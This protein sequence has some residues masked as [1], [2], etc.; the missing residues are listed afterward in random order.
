MFILD[1]LRDV[2]DGEIHVGAL[3]SIIY[4][5][6]ASVYSERPYGVIYPKTEEDIVQIINFASLH[7]INLIPRAAGTSLAGQVVG[8]G[9]AVDITKYFNQIIEVNETEQYA[10]VQPG[11]VRDELN[12]QLQNTGLFF[13]PET[14]TSNRC[15][16]GGMVGNN[17]CGANSLIYGSTRQHIISLKAILSDGSSVEF[18]ELT[19]QEFQDKCKLEN[20]EGELYRNIYNL[21]SPEEIQQEIREQFPDKSIQR[22]SMG[23]AIDELIDM[24]PF[25]KNGNPFNL[26][27]LIAGSEGTLAFITEIKVKLSPLPHPHKA[28]LSVQTNSIEEAL[29]G[30]IIALAYKPA[31]IELIDGVILELAKENRVQNKNRFFIKDNPAAVLIIEVVENSQE[32]VI[33]KIKN[34]Q[35]ALQKASIGNYFTVIE[36]DDMSRVWALRKSGLGIMSNAKGDA[37]PATVVE[38]V[39]IQPEKYPQYYQEFKKLLD[40]F[41]LKCAF[42]AHIS[43]GELHNKPI[44]N[45]KDKEEVKKF[46]EFAYE[47]ALLVK[48]LGGCLSGEHGDGRLRG[49][50]LPIMIGETCYKIC[51]DI[52]QL[53]DPH[54]IFNGEKIVNAPLMNKQLRFDTPPRFPFNQEPKIEIDKYAI[55][56]IFDFSDT[57]GIL[58]AIEKCNG[59]ADCK[60]S[61]LFGGTMCPSYHAT[62]NEQN[63]TR[64]R[65]NIL[66][67]VITQSYKDNPFDHQQIFDILDHCL[68][69]KACKTECPSNIDMTKLKAEF[70]HHYYQQHLM[71]LRSVLIS[72]YP[73][74][75]QLGIAIA[76]I[77]NVFCTNKRLSKLLKKWVGFAT[78]RSLPTVHAFSLRKWAKKHLR[79]IENPIK[80]VYLFN[81]EFTNTND[82]QIGIKSIKLLEAL[83]YQVKL[84]KH[85]YSGRTFLSKGNI[86]KAKKLAEKNVEIFSSY[87][88]S[89]CPLL[90][91]EPSAILSFRDEYPDIVDDSMKSKAKSLAKHCFM[92]DEFIASEYL[93]GK[94]DRTLFTTASAEIIFHA[95][96][97][98]KALSETSASITIMEIPENY[99]V[100]EIKSGC[101]GMAGSF[102]FEKE[103]YELSM[104]IGSL[105]LFPTINARESGTIISATGTSCRHQ[106]K[107]GT[108]ELSLHPVEVLYEALVN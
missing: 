91:I 55:N 84:V 68:S 94:I 39:A 101:C 13:A 81:D 10:I 27:T 14:A 105:T 58:R 16:I 6:D 80:S 20:R 15:R 95:H 52:K 61:H 33:Q 9:F 2:V 56:T 5:T 4:A 89:E 21:L 48:K 88:D 53:F 11:V 74:F 36:G 57:D 31:S 24:Q 32:A 42:Y 75:N 93:Q 76:P 51:Q 103:H 28:L 8:K 46:R 67:E 90:G 83:G 18:K 72:Y 79:L 7:N 50:F 77:Y 40:R 54:Q 12:L 22:R 29:E 62:L 35:D 108:G 104:Q 17:S 100:K 63:S 65:A 102:G 49:E 85:P 78:E 26:C 47:N 34:I 64:A 92:I 96:C 60:R 87:I 99:H 66:R 69:C 70:L 25:T 38:D 73:F 107:D 23:Y 59:S 30:N 44:F 1:E 19:P 86:K 106:I 97:Y 3:S 98:Q 45:L 37:K 41:D 71:P 82:I 43:T